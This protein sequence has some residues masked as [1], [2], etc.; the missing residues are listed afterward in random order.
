MSILSKLQ[1]SLLLGRFTIFVIPAV[2]TIHFTGPSD[3]NDKIAGN[4]S[5]GIAAY[6]YIHRTIPR[7]ADQNPNT[8][9]MKE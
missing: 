6:E 8:L 2:Y 3:E 1:V 4:I 5:D 9:N 7:S